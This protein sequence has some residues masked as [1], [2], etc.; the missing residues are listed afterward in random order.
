MQVSILKD[1]DPQRRKDDRDISTELAS[2]RPEHAPKL[3][4][5]GIHRPTFATEHAKQSIPCE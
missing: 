4:Q 1:H 3:P 2:S 5:R